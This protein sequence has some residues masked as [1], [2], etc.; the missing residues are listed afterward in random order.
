MCA[1]NLSAVYYHPCFPDE[2]T[3]GR[4]ERASQFRQETRD[5]LCW[6]NRGE[7]NKMTIYKAVGK[8]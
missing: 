7:F 2:E 1:N 5:I 4:W 3:E 6:V 8:D